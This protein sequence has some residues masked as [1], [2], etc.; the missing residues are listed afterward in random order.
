MTWA[1]PRGRYRWSAAPGRFQRRRRF[2]ETDEGRLAFDV[3]PCPGLPEGWTRAAYLDDQEIS[4]DELELRLA[5]LQ[6]EA[7]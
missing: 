6:R 3:E 4:D 1:Y 7:C 5:A 2:V